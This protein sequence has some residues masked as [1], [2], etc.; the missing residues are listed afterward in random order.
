MCLRA[1]GYY[2]SLQAVGL[3]MSP[4]WARTLPGELKSRLATW[5]VKVAVAAAGCTIAHRF[6]DCARLA[7][8]WSGIFDPRIE[9]IAW[10]SRPGWASIVCAAGLALVSLGTRKNSPGPHYR[11]AIG[12][13]ITVSS[14][15]LTGHTSE[16]GLAPAIHL[17]PALH[18]ALVGF[19]LGGISVLQLTAR[20]GDLPASAALIRGFSAAAIWLVPA[21]AVAGV[22][23]AAALVPDP[24][25]LLTTHYG[26]LLLLKALLF[27]ALLALAAINRLVLA[28][29]IALG[30]VN[31]LQR[32]RSVLRGE[33]GLLTCALVVTA[34]LTTLAGPHDL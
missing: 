21:I 23:I 14:F 7:G 16:P 9:H 2:L 10:W 25:A 4:S 15:S 20:T 24:R 33:H 3:A 29:R 32:F 6:L 22:L 12:V 26:E 1:V 18:L 30:D 5:A 28:S 19:W 27:S 13:L 17:L 34:V 11:A 31:A 8:A